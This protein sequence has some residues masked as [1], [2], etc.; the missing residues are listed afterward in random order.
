MTTNRTQK[1]TLITRINFQ[2][3][4]KTNKKREKAVTQRLNRNYSIESIVNK[5]S[6]VIPYERKCLNCYI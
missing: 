2:M 6:K 5:L 3:Q 4:L 1:L